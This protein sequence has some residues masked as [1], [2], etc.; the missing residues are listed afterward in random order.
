M[1]IRQ[2]HHLLATLLAQGCAPELAEPHWASL[3]P[4]SWLVAD[5]PSQPFVLLPP[6]LG[7]N[8]FTRTR[9]WEP[10]DIQPLEGIP[11]T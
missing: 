9:K 11:Q 6:H 10:C 1:E 3:L 2:D 5:W 8:A 4:F 7:G